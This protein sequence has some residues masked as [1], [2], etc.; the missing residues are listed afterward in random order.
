MT[1]IQGVVQLL[2][3]RKHTRLSRQEPPTVYLYFC[4]ICWR[5]EVLVT[6]MGGGNATQGEFVLSH[7]PI[8]WSMWETK[9]KNHNFISNVAGCM[10]LRLPLKH[11][12][13]CAWWRHP[14]CLTPVEALVISLRVTPTSQDMLGTT[15]VTEWDVT[16][17][18]SAHF[19][20]GLLRKYC[21]NL[22]WQTC[23]CAVW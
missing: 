12:D 11:W 23:Q 6:I 13:V 3:E 5:E 20:Q 10:W 7:S 16:F 22:F 15:A 1:L 2:S 14:S 9:T 4:P 21:G 19:H 18:Y 17:Q 8:L